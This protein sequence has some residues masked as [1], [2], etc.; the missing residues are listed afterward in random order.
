M[1][2][3]AIVRSDRF[4]ICPLS[5]P[6][7]NTLGHE[8]VRYG[9]RFTEPVTAVGPNRVFAANTIQAPAVRMDLGSLSVII[10][11]TLSSGLPTRNIKP[12]LT[13][14]LLAD[15]YHTYTLD[16][17]R[18]NRIRLRHPFS[19]SGIPSAIYSIGKPRGLR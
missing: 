7:L 6:L 14:V 11:G 9:N 8:A 1:A 3:I 5:P 12:S 15:K 17:K 10:S 18:R 16:A 2:F 19:L 13:A 4:Y